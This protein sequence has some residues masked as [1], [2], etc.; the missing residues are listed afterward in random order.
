M[1]HIEHEH[2]NIKTNGV[3]DDDRFEGIIANITSDGRNVVLLHFPIM[4][5]LSSILQSIHEKTS[6]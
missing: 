1:S 3:N 4:I 2:E 5:I 6:P